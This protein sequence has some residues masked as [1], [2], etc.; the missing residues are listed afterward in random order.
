MGKPRPDGTP[1]QKWAILQLDDGTVLDCF[2]FAK[3]WEQFGAQIETAVDKLVLLCGEISH[4][5]NYEKDDKF[6]KKNP[7]VGDLNFTVKEAYPLENA[8][9]LLSKGLRVKMEYADPEIKPKV[10][11]IREAIKKNPGNLPV[12]IELHYPSGK[13]LDV[14]LGAQFRVAG[15]ISFLSELGK[16]VPPADT[17]FRPDSKIYLAP[18]EPKPWER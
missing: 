13:V 7:T 5:V 16:I 2:C 15:S 12:I 17:S 9:P 11:R 14:D 10:D 18:R 1:G 4:R 3:P 8:L 6:E